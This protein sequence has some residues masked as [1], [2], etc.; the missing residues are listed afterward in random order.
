MMSLASLARNIRDVVL[1]M[2][3]VIVLA[4]VLVVTNSMAIS[5]RERTRE[6]AV[7][8]ALGFTDGQVLRLVLGEAVLL[9]LSGGVLGGAFAYAIFASSG[10]D[11]G[12]GPAGHFAV[13]PLALAAGLALSLLIGVAAGSFPAL[14]ASRLRIVEALRWVR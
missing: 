13:Q 10:F 7:L 6:M 14:H 8:K 4:I 9:A 2:G 1:A 11:L 5:V 3:L 12:S